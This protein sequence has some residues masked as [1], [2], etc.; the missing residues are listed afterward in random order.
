MTNTYHHGSVFFCSARGHGNSASVLFLQDLRLRR[1]GTASVLGSIPAAS[2]NPAAELCVASH[3]RDV[4][5]W[6]RWCCGLLMRYPLEMHSVQVD[7]TPL[8]SHFAEEDSGATRLRV[9]SRE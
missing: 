6:G 9:G 7:T 5:S 8:F 3:S 4:T 1:L 2:T